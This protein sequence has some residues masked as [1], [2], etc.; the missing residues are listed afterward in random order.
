MAGVTYGIDALLLH[1]GPSYR[2]AGISRSIQNLL[3]YLPD[4][5]A[6][7]ERLVAYSGP[8]AI[9][10]YLARTRLAFS[11]TRLPT[12][13]PQ[14]RI[15][16]E[17][18]V[19]PVLAA[20]AGVSA[21]H[22]PAY[23]APLVGSVPSVVTVHDL[24]FIRFPWAFNRAN[25]VYLAAMTR[26]SVRHADALVAVSVSTRDEMTALLGIDPNKVAVICHG[27]EP[28]YRQIE[29]RAQV[30]SFRR[31]RGLPPHFTLCV[32]T[33]EPRKNLEMLV[34]AYARAGASAS[35][36]QK[37]VLAGG[38]GWGYQQVFAL[39]ERLGLG[40]DIIFPG[41]VPM[42]DLPLWY[43]AAD[44][45]V[46]PS[47]YEGFGMPVLEAMACGV[48]TV[49]TTTPALREVAGSACVLVD[50]DSDEQLADTLSSII[51]SPDRLGEMRRSGLQRAAEFSWERSARQHLDVYRSVRN[52]HAASRQHRGRP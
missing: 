34:R 42:S 18:T 1:F 49:T 4:E 33:L 23:V 24:S 32:A 5:F 22:C 39:V 36:G 37:L 19:L 21:L 44:L 28:E 17:Q 50:P 46:Y 8:G 25:R 11:Q 2:A 52:R 43:N 6:D 9:P 41:F 3:R 30:E 48:P 31:D 26:W 29:D 20:R 14:V 16:W 40:G 35:L 10:N 13:R 51:A 15:L 7:N 45:F 12:H 47:R 38:K 27:I